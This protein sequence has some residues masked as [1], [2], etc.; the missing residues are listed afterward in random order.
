MNFQN[1]ENNMK[2]IAL[3]ILLAAI[4]LP[5]V[6]CSDDDDNPVP[7]GINDD[8]FSVPADATDEESV[9]RR[10]FHDKTGIHLLFSEILKSTVI[11]KD[12]NG[13]DII[14]N[15]TIDFAWDYNSDN[16]GLEYEMVPF[17]DD[18]LAGKRKAADLFVKEIL[19]HIEGSTIS[20][21]SVLLTTSLKWREYRYD[22]WST[23]TMSCWRCLAVDVEGWVNSSTQEE[24]DAW[25]TAICKNIVKDRFSCWSTEAKP[26]TTISINAGAGE[27]LSD[28]FD[29]WDRDITR[30]YELGFMSYRQT[31]RPSYD[32]LPYEDSDF[33][34]FYD[35]VFGRTQE[36]FEAEFGQYA[37][38]MEKYNLMKSL[39][40]QTG[41]KF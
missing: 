18:D 16:S 41:Y 26:W 39:I 9:L 31:S 33:N 8:L 35:A 24:S 6:S 36:D 22:S 27:Y 11:G 2:K 28:L 5:F 23:Y 13:N 17:E 15:E 10:E 14:K 40:E 1:K 19:P 20:P 34:A 29:D 7:S 21:Y 30:V 4:G 37:K 12:A 32:S 38:I 25:T 3:Y